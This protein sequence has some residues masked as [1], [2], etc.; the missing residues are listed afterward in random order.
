MNKD[1]WELS[2]EEKVREMFLSP[3]LP[4]ATIKIYLSGLQDPHLKK[5]RLGSEDL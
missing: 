4:L 2:P 3:E 5:E 1:T